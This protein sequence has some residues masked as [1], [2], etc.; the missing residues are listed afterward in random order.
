MVAGR[1]TRGGMDSPQRYRL[2]GAH[3]ETILGIS[4]LPIGSGVCNS[5]IPGNQRRKKENCYV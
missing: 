5:A 1:T 2:C 4:Q 3:T